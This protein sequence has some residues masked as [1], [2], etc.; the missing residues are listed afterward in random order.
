MVVYH[1]PMINVK[2][3]E[4]KTISVIIDNTVERNAE[5]GRAI[6]AVKGALPD[7][8]WGLVGGGGFEIG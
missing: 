5:L 7:G 2:T 4:T 6:Q 8:R 3:L 1:Y